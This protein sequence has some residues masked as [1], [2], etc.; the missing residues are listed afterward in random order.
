MRYPA[1]LKP[2]GDAYVVTFRDIP[3]ALTQ[4]DSVEDALDMAADALLTAMDFYVEDRRAVPPPSEP[5]RGEYMV[6]LPASAAAKLV[7]LNEMIAQH[8]RPIDLATSIGT[9]KQAVNRLTD[10]H[11]ATKIDAIA[12]ALAA[13]GKRLDFTLTD[14]ERTTKNA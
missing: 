8:I 2:E 13:L 1:R 9:T 6:A 7:L 11:H 5:K 4:G 14:I 12:D 3:E 10:L